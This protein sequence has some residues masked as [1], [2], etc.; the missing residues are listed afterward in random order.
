MTNVFC[1]IISSSFPIERLVLTFGYT[2]I[3]PDLALTKVRKGNF[4][5]EVLCFTCFLVFQVFCVT[6]FETT[7]Q[8]LQKKKKQKS[9]CRVRDDDIATGSH[10]S[11]HRQRVTEDQCLW[12]SVFALKLLC[13]NLWQMGFLGLLGCFC[14]SRLV[15]KFHTKCI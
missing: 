11:L 3:L 13:S 4:V 8:H 6:P 15:L 1:T 2:T 14:V 9:K 12:C 5:D 7:N 10:K